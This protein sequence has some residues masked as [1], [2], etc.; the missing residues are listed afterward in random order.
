[1]LSNKLAAKIRSSVPPAPSVIED[2]GA[3]APAINIGRERADNI[4]RDS[5]GAGR[6]PNSSPRTTG[7]KRPDVLRG[8]ESVHVGFVRSEIYSRCEAW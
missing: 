1:M 6:K 3:L 2:M 7:A 8:M 5:A 4:T